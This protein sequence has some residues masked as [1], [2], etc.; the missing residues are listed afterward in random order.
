MAEPPE[1]ADPEPIAP[2]WDEKAVDALVRT[3]VA[4][5]STLTLEVRCAYT[6]CG[7]A[8]CLSPFLTGPE[9]GVQFA[10]SDH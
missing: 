5:T 4:A 6:R 10:L 2:V 9:R 7:A 1:T 8:V 3:L